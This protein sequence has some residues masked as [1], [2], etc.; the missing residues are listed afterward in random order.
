MIINVDINESGMKLDDIA[1]LV[2]SDKLGK[3]AASE[4]LRLYKPYVPFETGA[5]STSVAIEPWKITH[6]APYAHYQYEGMV[7]GPS[8]PLDDG[9]RWISPK[10]KK[11][12]PTGKT[13]RYRNPRA[14]AKWDQAAIPTQQQKLVEALQA[15]INQGLF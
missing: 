12:Y 7:Y 10:G 14:A 11:K 15:F 4:W 6:T 13:L 5:L 2:S 1:T 8:F 9:A 3:F